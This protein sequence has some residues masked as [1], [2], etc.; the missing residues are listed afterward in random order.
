MHLH[1]RA[2]HSLLPAAVDD[3]EAYEYHDGEL[4][5]GYVLG[6]NFGD[7]HLHQTQL[8]EAVQSRCQFAEGDLRCIF[9]ESQPLMGATMRY[10]IHDAASGLQS[11]GAV[12]VAQLQEEQPWPTT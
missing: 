5:A 12:S 6:W 11:E 1:G 2:L 7:G 8:L 10:S 4:I 9:I 3:L